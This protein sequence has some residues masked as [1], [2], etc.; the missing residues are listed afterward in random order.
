[1]KG[2]HLFS[3]LVA[4]ADTKV[5]LSVMFSFYLVLSVYSLHSSEVFAG[6]LLLA[7]IFGLKG[8]KSKLQ[9]RPLSLREKGLL[10]SFALYTL[11]SVASFLY[12]PA[13]RDAH[14]RVEDDLKFLMFIPLYLLFREYRFN[15]HHLVVLLIVFAVSMG[16]VS[17]GQFLNIGV[18]G[19]IYGQSTRPAADVN[20]M[21]YAV[22][23]LLVS[24][25][26]LSYWFAF[27][28][29]PILIR[30]I[31]L[32]AILLGLIACVLTQTRGVWIS[33]PILILLYTAYS[34]RHLG[35]RYV[36]M[37]LSVCSLL[38][39]MSAQT[40]FVQER[41]KLTIDSLDRFQA[42]SGLTSLGV[43]LDMY[44]ASI[45]LAKEKPVFGHGLGVFKEK[46]RELRES[47]VLGDEVHEQ[48]GK[49]RTP[50]N[51][52]F[53]AVVERGV[54]GVAVT[55]LLFFVPGVIFF[56]AVRSKT[57]D[58]SYYGLCGLSLLI[59]FFVAGQTGTLFNHNLF[60]NFYIIMVMLFVSQIKWGERKV[61]VDQVSL[62]T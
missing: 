39:F 59:V 57:E 19:E 50:H 54:V 40:P 26:C 29:K 58:G 3:R 33:I 28:A 10:F 1:M 12:W 20:P 4:F 31:L 5:M 11:V 22:V 42:G 51:E 24:C 49:R 34:F 44:K 18:I 47:G 45:I 7:G 35:L 21:R 17:L 36:V 56:R 52:F 8:V 62:E 2:F 38:L 9:S 60:T 41:L 61:G 46:S 30:L 37:L 13:T 25:F 55:M 6:I 48:V 53:Q 14:M 27:R 23:A 16:I 32:F 43:R 15:Q